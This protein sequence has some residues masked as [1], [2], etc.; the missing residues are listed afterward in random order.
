M[1]PCPLIILIVRFS[2]FLFKHWQVLLGRALRN[3]IY[4]LSTI[5]H[6]LDMVDNDGRYFPT[7]HRAA[8]MLF[9]WVVWGTVRFLCCTWS[10]PIVLNVRAL[11]RSRYSCL[12]C[13]QTSAHSLVQSLRL[14]EN[15]SRFW[16]PSCFS[17]TLWRTNNGLVQY[18]FLVVYSWTSS[19]A[20]PRRWV[21]KSMRTIHF[22]LKNSE[23]KRCKSSH[24]SVYLL[25]SESTKVHPSPPIHNF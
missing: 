16:L 11:F 1:G 12:L 2:L 25:S 18:L 17:A 10:F 13:W 4:F 14:Q 15:S 23:V 6:R 5:T 8:K 20:N 22:L 9:N 19:T 3:L 24:I 7:V 21:R